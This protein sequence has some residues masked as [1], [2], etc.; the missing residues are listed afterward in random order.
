MVAVTGGPLG[1]DDAG[2]T[3][4]VGV[5]EDEDPG[6][7]AGPAGG[8]VARRSPAFHPADDDRHEDL[9]RGRQDLGECRE[10]LEDEVLPPP[11]EVLMPVIIGGM[12]GRRPPRDAPAGRPGR[13]AGVLVLLYP[14]ADGLA[15]VV[16]TERA[17]RDGHHGHRG[18]LPGRVGR[19]P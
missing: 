3:V 10:T 9:G 19:T 8:R 16:L 2:E 15:R 4:R 5:E 13:P 18:Q 11:A 17:T 7:T 1:Q 6:R 12:E 14:D